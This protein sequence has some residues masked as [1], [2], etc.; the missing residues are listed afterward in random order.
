MG[1]MLELGDLSKSAHTCLGEEIAKQRV[2]VLVTVGEL[3]SLAAQG[4]RAG[5]MKEDCVLDVGT[6]EE[7]TEF[8]RNH[9]RPGDCLLFKG[10]RGAGMEK[11]IED[12]IHS[13]TH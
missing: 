10:S 6:R 11:V 7:A 8:L 5:G 2:D 3:A 4:A 1:N 13:E 9:I 12:L